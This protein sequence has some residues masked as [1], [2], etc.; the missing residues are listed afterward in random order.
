MIDITAGSDPA[1]R[2]APVRRGRLG[3]SDVHAHQRGAAGQVDHGQQRVQEVEVKYKIFDV[4]ALL[5]ALAARGVSM[6]APV[7]QDDQA[8]A[9]T[10]W[11]YGQSKIGVP[12]AR[13]RTE[14]GRHLFTVKTPVD[15]EMACVEHECEIADRQQ[16]HGAV[17]AMG[18]YPT[19]RIVKTRRT[20]VLGELSLYLDEVERAGVFLEVEQ[21]MPP[22]DSGVVAQQRLDEFVRSL[23]VPGER[24]S[25][26]YDSLV[27]AAQPTEI[28]V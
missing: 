11:S 10:E 22:G 27:R 20:G 12:F 16:M 4:E 18:F 23:G 3:S 1:W 14:R 13:L 26:T 17:L 25:D 9:P 28:P 24:T 8:Y 7:L 15:N 5:R 6:S 2:T 19:V 21:L